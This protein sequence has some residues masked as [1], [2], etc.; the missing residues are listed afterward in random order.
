MEN[1]FGRHF[2]L[3]I[4]RALFHPQ[5]AVLKGL[6]HSQVMKEPQKTK[7]FVSSLDYFLAFQ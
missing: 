5:Y 7:Y 4:M 2:G 6:L 3:Q 1:T